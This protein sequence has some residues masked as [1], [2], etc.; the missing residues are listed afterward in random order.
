MSKWSLLKSAVLNVRDVE[1]TSSIHRFKGFQIIDKKKAFFP[2]FVFDYHIDEGVVESA[3]LFQHFMRECEEFMAQIDICECFVQI[4]TTT[5]HEGSLRE[6]L[7]QG[8]EIG[9]IRIEDSIELKKENCDC[10]PEK[11]PMMTAYVLSRKRSSACS[12]I[13]YWIYSLSW[14]CAEGSDTLSKIVQ[15]RTRERRQNSRIGRAGILSNVLHGVDNTGNVCVWP[16]EN[17]L[18]CSILRNP[19]LLEIVSGKTILEIGGG[20]TGL[21]GL[22]LGASGYCKT[23]VIT[24]GHPDCVSNQVNC[25]FSHYCY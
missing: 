11:R 17:V 18:L 5:K 10:R 6:A 25:T 2:R 1:S 8:E 14:Q 15:V 19:V 20:M 9:L 22:G 7:K 3:C 23:I 24:D 12:P 13:D 16:A 21:C 4:S